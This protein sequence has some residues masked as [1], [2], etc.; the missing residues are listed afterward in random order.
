MG[1]RG[2]LPT[3]KVEGFLLQRRAK[4]DEINMDLQIHK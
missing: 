3:T 1:Q 2:E 4:L